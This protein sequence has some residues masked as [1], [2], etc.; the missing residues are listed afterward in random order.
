MAEPSRR[1]FGTEVLSE[2][3]AY[4]FEAQTTL[5]F[6]VDGFRFRLRL[7]LVPTVGH[8]LASAEAEA[9]RGAGIDGGS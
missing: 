6:E 2:T 4:E 5:D 9:S 1:G 8:V 3:L 7:P